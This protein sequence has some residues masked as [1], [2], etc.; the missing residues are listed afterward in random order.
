MV[1]PDITQEQ[2]RSLLDYDPETGAFTWLRRD[3]DD[4]GDKIFNGR[5]AGKRADTMREDGYTRIRPTVDGVTRSYQAH[6]L[7]WLYIH[8]TFPE[9]EIDHINRNRSDNRIV[10]LRPAT[11]AENKRNAPARKTNKS[12]YK[13][14]VDASAVNPSKPWCAYI[15]ID[16]KNRNLGYFSTK[17]EASAAYKAAALSLHGEFANYATTEGARP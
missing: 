12:G 2:V 8:G 15:Q 3:S 6:R 13:G 17:Q 4:I 7:A 9:N 11:S 10:N 16:K 5:F 14:V 1:V